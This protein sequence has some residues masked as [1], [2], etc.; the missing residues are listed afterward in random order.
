MKSTARLGQVV[1]CPFLMAWSKVFFT[2]L[3]S[4]TWYHLDSYVLLIDDSALSAYGCCLL[5]GWSELLVRLTCHMHDV[6]ERL[7]SNTVSLSLTILS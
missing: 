4:V 2:G 5:G 1:N 7:P 3:N 6:F